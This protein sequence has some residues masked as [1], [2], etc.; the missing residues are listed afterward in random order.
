M[1]R[2]EQDT[3]QV[4]AVWL[5][6]LL[7]LAGPAESGG[8][9]DL[10]P[11]VGR[12]KAMLSY[13][14]GGGRYTVSRAS[15]THVQRPDATSV[16]FSIKPVVSDRPVF[17]TRLAYDAATRDFVETVRNREVLLVDRVKLTYSE[18]VGF[19]GE[20]HATDVAGKSHPVQIRIAA[21]AQGY[22]WTFSDPRAPAENNTL[23]TF[24]FLTRIEEP[25]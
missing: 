3:N 16:S 17:E 23:F 19:S 6:L 24:T 4:T 5:I 9:G 14:E 7:S 22:E 10:K 13:T 18:G 8:S 20:G 12:W 11:F 1:A 25:R 2:R 15:D 21:K